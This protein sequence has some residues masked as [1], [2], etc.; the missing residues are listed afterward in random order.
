[1]RKEAAVSVL[2]DPSIPAGKKLVFLRLDCI[3][4]MGAGTGLWW[5]AYEFA[6]GSTKPEGMFADEDE[7]R[8]LARELAARH[9]VEVSEHSFA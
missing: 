9:G 6:D 5:V 3:S 4:R 8:A 7:A 2:N 1:M